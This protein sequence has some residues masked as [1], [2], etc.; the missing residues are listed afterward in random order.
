MGNTKYEAVHGL[1]P[2]Q[3]FDKSSQS[4]A[5][6]AHWCEEL[7]CRVDALTEEVKALK[8]AAQTEN[9]PVKQKK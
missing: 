9:N 7:T 5:N 1:K 8:A 3:C 4:N 6:V 2:G